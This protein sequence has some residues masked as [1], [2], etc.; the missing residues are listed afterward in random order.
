M[1]TKKK[2]KKPAK[3]LPQGLIQ[4][5]SMRDVLPDTGDRKKSLYVYRA[6]S[7]I[8]HIGCRYAAREAAAAAQVTGRKY[9]IAKIARC[10][11]QGFR[12]YQAALAEGSRVAAQ[13]GRRATALLTKQ[14]IGKEGRRVEVVDRYGERRRF[15]VGRSTGWM[16]IHLE[17][18]RVS[19]RGGG[20][21]MGA[22]FKSVR[23]LG[24]CG[25]GSR[26]R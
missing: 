14:L 25:S 22:P 23:D 12:V 3:P 2:A 13:T 17:V 15:C 24:P 1:A 26:R 4:I 5:A 6:G 18:A 9:P 10:T 16:P 11:R 8:H 21:V 19:S 7:G 20:G